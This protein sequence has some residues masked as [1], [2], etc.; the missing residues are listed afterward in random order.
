[1]HTKQRHSI[2][3]LV[4]LS[5][6]TLAACSASPPHD[7]APAARVDEALTA[8]AFQTCPLGSNAIVIAFAPEGETPACTDVLGDGGEWIYSGPKKVRTCTATRDPERGQPYA[9]AYN[10]SPGSTTPS[11][12]PDTRALDALPDA[13]VAEATGGGATCGDPSTLSYA[14]ILDEAGVTCPATPGSGP[15]NPRPCEVCGV[16]IYPGV[17]YGSMWLPASNGLHTVSVGLSNGTHQILSI[18]SP[19]M[20]H[21]VTTQS[22]GRHAYVSITLPDLPKGVDYE[23]GPALG[24]GYTAHVTR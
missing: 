12:S 14:A 24:Y 13:Y 15:D 4:A 17:I 19:A 10:W 20:N 11:A 16:P 22:R 3:R 1:M 21:S 6:P 8:D 7:D 5:L 23:D 9:C 18:A 2:A